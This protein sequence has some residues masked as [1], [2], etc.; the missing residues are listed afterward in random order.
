MPL[1]SSVAVAVAEAPAAALIQPLAPELPC[2]AGAALKRKEKKRFKGQLIRTLI[3]LCC[4]LDARAALTKCQRLGG[5]TTDLHYF[6]V[7]EAG[8]P[9]S[10]CCHG[11][12]LARALFLAC[13]RPPSL[14]VLTRHRGRRTDRQ[15]SD[16]SC[17]TDT[18]PHSSRPHLN[19]I[20][21]QTPHRTGGYDFSIRM[22]WPRVQ[23]SPVDHCKVT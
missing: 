9:R 7:L 18:N 1:R 16:A 13:R 11:Q 17:H 6:T 15:L 5:N 8:R 23:P 19:L 20:I 14:C 10:R 22:W 3:P 21:F 2:A 4:A 12:V